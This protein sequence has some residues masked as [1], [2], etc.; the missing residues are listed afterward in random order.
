MNADHFASEQARKY[1]VYV[2]T[3]GVASE[4]LYPRYKPDATEPFQTAQEMIIYLKQFF[5]NPHR[6]RDARYEYQNL[7][8]KSSESFFEFQT[9]FLRLAN[10]AEIA[11]S[12]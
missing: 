12:E 1:Q 5:Q 2:C 3:E 9:I 7:R 4:Y 11:R 8:I 6:I 10:K